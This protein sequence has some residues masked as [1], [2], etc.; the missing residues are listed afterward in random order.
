MQ[1]NMFSKCIEHNAQIERAICSWVSDC[2]KENIES[3]ERLA[4][5]TTVMRMM[6]AMYSIC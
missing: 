2:T 4:D 6:H 5:G 1:A 3:Y